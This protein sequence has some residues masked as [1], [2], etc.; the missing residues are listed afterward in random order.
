METMTLAEFRAALKRQGVPSHENFAFKC[1]MC[2]TVQSG[3]DLIKAGAGETFDDVEKY[4]AFS[5]IGCFTGA[6]KKGESTGRGCNWTLGGLFRTHKLE[7]VTEDGEHHP[8][9]ALATA[10][11]AQAHMHAN[12]EINRPAA[13]GSG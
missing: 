4:L 11:E 3:A 1:P 5:C 2:G 12:D 7:V 13:S 10:E 6:P 9:F 8:R